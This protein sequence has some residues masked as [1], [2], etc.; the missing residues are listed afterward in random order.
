MSKSRPPGIESNFRPL[1]FY[2]RSHQDS[3]A[4]QAEEVRLRTRQLRR[5]GKLRDRRL[6]VSAFRPLTILI[7]P[8][9]KGKTAPG[10]V[11]TERIAFHASDATHVR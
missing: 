2:F 5:V 3:R 11:V 9:N 4:R 10:G 6:D 1:P 8:C 7:Y